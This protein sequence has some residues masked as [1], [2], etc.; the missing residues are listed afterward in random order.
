MTGN[1]LPSL[2][3]NHFIK[4]D[5]II[6]FIILMKKVNLDDFLGL[7]VMNNLTPKKL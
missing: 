5:N 7:F 3:S 2:N 4:V 1:L 6:Y